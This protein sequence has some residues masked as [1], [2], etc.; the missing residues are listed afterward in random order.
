MKKILILSVTA[1]N[2]HN[3]CAKGMKRKLEELAGEEVE[4]KIIDTLK[5]FSTP[6]EVWYADKGYNLAVSKFLPIYHMFYNHFKKLDPDKRWTGSTQKTALSCAGGLLKEL[7]CFQPDVVYCTHFYP[8]IAMT[9]LKL[10]YDLPCKVV[11]SNLDYVNSPFWESAIGV[12]YFIVPNEDFVEE[13]MEEGFKYEQLLP[14]GLPVDGRTL[15][16]W[17]RKEARAKLG[18]KD[19]VFTVMVMFGGGCWKG[20]RK[21]FDNIIKSLKGKEA[22][23]IMINGKNEIDYK[24]IEKM[25][26]PKNIK[27]VNVGF[28]SEVPLYMASADV[29]VNKFGGTSVTEMINVGRPMLIT[30]KIPTQELYNLKYMKAKGVALSFKNK[31]ELS[32]NLNLLYDNPKMRQE[33]E[34]KTLLLKKNTIDDLANLMLSF[35]NANYDVLYNKQG[36]GN[37]LLDCEEV[38]FG[39]Q[40][41]ENKAVRK[42]VEKAMKTAHKKSMK[43]RQTRKKEEAELKYKVS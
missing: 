34:E 14:L 29:I 25:T 40:N 35:D 10:V 30:E 6:S 42:V 1:G 28:T 41:K 12:D 9:D 26:F 7:L 36:M 3:A 17:D 11:V 2:G 31:K 22:Q 32:K 16:K 13:S 33:M 5:T 37:M 24:R 18:L 43:D 8:A 20:G 23:V 39:Y 27:V 15:E 4:V 38:D 21:I 19:N